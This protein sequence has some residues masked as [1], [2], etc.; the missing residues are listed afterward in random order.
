MFCNLPANSN[1]S[2][3]INYVVCLIN[4]TL[5]PLLISIAVVGFVYGVI[6]YFIVGA[7]EEAKR[8]QGKQFIIWGII[9][10]VVLTSLWALVR[11][12]GGTF[13]LRT[14]VLP[15]TQP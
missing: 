11:I 13:G 4:R 9:A 2:Q 12:L 14:G 15:G 10:F 5:I 3:I 6:Q 7:S 1:L 8:E